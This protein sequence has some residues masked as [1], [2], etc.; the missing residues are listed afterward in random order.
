MTMP[1]IEQDIRRRLVRYR[2]SMIVAYI[3]SSAY[4]EEGV[5]TAARPDSA[6]GGE[7]PPSVWA[8]VKPR[9]AGRIRDQAKALIPE[10]MLTWIRRLQII[11]AVRKHA[12]NWR[13]T[14]APPDRLAAFDSDMRR[15]VG[16]IRAIGAV[17]V[18]V[19]HGDVLMG[20]P[21]PDKDQLIGWEKFYPRATGA[22]LVAFDSLARLTVLHV[23]A[24]S[25]TISVDAARDLAAGP[26]AAFADPTHFTDLG[27]ATVARVVSR[28]ILTVD[29]RVAMCGLR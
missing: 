7:R 20:R 12:S 22:T 11:N 10:A 29:A 6:G 13:F 1:T 25:N 18:L 4:L 8:E 9:S 19:T 27:A 3:P 16:A 2:P 28:E 24:D 5:P 14:T 23:A 26:V 15:L 17:P 21:V